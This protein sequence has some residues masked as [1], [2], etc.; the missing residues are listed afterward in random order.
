MIY[1]LALAFPLATLLLA[2]VVAAQMV[3]YVRTA[4]R[5]PAAAEQNN[6]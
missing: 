3:A 4:F 1:I 6:D 5:S 2:A